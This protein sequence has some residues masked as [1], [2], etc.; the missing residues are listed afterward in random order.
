MHSLFYCLSVFYHS[1]LP[2]IILNW[3]LPEGSLVTLSL[4]LCITAVCVLKKGVLLSFIDWQIK[5][6]MGK[7]QGSFA[8]TYHRV[9]P[10]IKSLAP[11]EPD[12]KQYYKNYSLP[13]SIC[14]FHSDFTISIFM[15]NILFISLLETNICWLQKMIITRCTLT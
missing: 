12:N 6:H 3:C 5:R 9:L 11:T 8:E 14:V 10:G 15:V 2:D 1:Y 13:N 4:F 7:R